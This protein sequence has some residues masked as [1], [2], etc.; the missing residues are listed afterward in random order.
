MFHGSTGSNW[1]ASAVAAN[2]NV[3]MGYQY[4]LNTVK[5]GSYWV[6]TTYK[7]S[8]IP[9]NQFIINDLIDHYDNIAHL[10]TATQGQ[11]NLGFAD[12]HVDTGKSTLTTSWLKSNTDGVTTSGL[13]ETDGI[14]TAINPLLDDL[15]KQS[16]Y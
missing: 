16:G 3:H 7:L 12:G 14:W 4:D 9:K 15:R 11:W 2:G 10:G 13:Q 6:P 5:S 1:F 8:Q